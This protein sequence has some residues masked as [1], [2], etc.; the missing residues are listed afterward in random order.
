MNRV[1]FV[2]LVMVSLLLGGV[3]F[4]IG[5]GQAAPGD[6][7]WMAPPPPPSGPMPPP[8]PRSP[9]SPKP[10]K[11]KAAGNGISISIRG[12]KIHIEGLDQ[13]VSGHLK[14]VRDWLN[15]NPNLPKDVRDKIVQ[16]MDRVNAI[17]D[18]HVK[19]LDTQDLN[20]LD[21]QLEKM[22]D[23]LEKAMQGLDA[24]LA[25]LGKLGKLG[26]LGDK[27]GKDLAMD[28]TKSL[29]K[30]FLKD[31]KFKFGPD[32]AKHDDDDDTDKSADIDIDTD[33]DTD[34]DTDDLPNAAVGPSTDDMQAS[35][36]M[37]KNF[38]LKPAQ[39][40]DLAKLRATTDAA[41]EGQ[42]KALDK[43]SKELEVALADVDVSEDIVRRYVD[44]ISAH[45]AAIRKERLL[46]W[47]KARR[48]L[49]ADQVKQLEAATHRTK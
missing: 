10:P 13:L 11:V 48:V 7:P 4:E 46:S 29:G 45:E 32:A 34:T 23:E 27:L 47:V 28:I 38:A 17:V 24:D 42:R 41:V 5:T 37:L 22:G 18:R 44:Q 8:V 6:D 25:Q 20:K 16:R 1:V 14:N 9:K 3:V 40:A 49:D 12:N 26:K 39:K 43:A 21:D 35:V 2:V 31:M 15:N 19:Q 36:D 33:T 30:D